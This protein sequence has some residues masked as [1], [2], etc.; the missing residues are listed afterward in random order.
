MEQAS[1]EAAAALRGDL[2]AGRAGAAPEDP[3]LRP[4]DSALPPLPTVGALGL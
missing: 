1:E 2:Q 3:D 4:P